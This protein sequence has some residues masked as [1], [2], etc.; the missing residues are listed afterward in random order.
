MYSDDKTW[1]QHYKDWVNILDKYEWADDDTT[2]AQF[3]YRKKII[4]DLVSEYETNHK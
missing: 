1:T 4:T 3:D 2:P